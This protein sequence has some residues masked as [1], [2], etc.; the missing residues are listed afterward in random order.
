MP[1]KERTGE[2]IIAALRQYEGETKPLTFA[3]SWV[4]ARHSS[5]SR[6]WKLSTCP[7]CIG[8]PGWMGCEPARAQ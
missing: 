3:G 6:P 2:Q 7:F 1:R 8:L 4:S 5:R